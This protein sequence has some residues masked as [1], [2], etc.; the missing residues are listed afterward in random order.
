MVIEQNHGA[1]FLRYLRGYF[2]LPAKPASYHR[3]GPLPLRPGEVHKAI[4]D[5]RKAA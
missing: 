4:A 1:Q 5:W 3:A 2:D